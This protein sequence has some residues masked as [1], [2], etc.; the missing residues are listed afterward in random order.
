MTVPG[1][2]IRVMRGDLERLP[3]SESAAAAGPAMVAAEGLGRVLAELPVVGGL[4][5]GNSSWFPRG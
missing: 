1:V 5:S 4:G 2:T 3:A